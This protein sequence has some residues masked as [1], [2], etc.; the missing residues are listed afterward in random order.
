MKILMFGWEFPPHNSGG[1][2]T[3]CYGLT[4]GLNHHGAK[5]TFVLPVSQ[6]SM[7]SD[8]VKLISADVSRGIEKIGINSPI[9]GYMTSKEYYSEYS[10][11]VLGYGEKRR[12][13][14]YGR[15]LFEEV[16]RYAAKAKLIAED[17]EFDVIHAHDWMTYQAGINAKKGSGK[18]FVIHVH[19]TEFDRTG[20]NPN[21]YVYDIEKHGMQEADKI[22]AVSNFTKDK[23]IKH[24]GISP[25]KIHVVHNA[26]EF[27]SNNFQQESFKIKE[28]DKVVLFLG[29]ITIQK[30]PDYFLYAAKKA[31]EL[32]PNIKFIVAGSGDMEQF[33]IEKAAEFGIADKVLFSGFLRGKDIDKAYQIADLYIMPSVSEPFGITPLESMR[34]NTPVLISK[35]SGVSEVVN[36]CLKVDFWDIDEIVNKMLGVLKYRELSEELKHHG[37]LEVKKFSWNNPAERCME[38]Y[39]KLMEGPKN[40]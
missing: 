30:G 2:G 12:S 17:E 35:Q 31:L 23:I 8:F 6:P 9:K 26:V 18:P 29:R 7:K 20:N 11:E 27:N 10:K 1:L 34:N 16:R 22:L 38:V 14:L 25:D 5:V 15:D 39:R 28:K 3:A 40:G 32:D 24:Y 13:P 33:M 37:S 21:Q 19:A 4:K 36:H